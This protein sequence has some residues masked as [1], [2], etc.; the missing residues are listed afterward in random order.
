MVKKTESADTLLLNK[1]IEWMK[2]E[3]EEIKAWQNKIIDT[4][5]EWNDKNDKKYAKK[6]DVDI[7]KRALI[8]IVALIVGWVVT[9]L[10]SKIWL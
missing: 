7:L 5:N 1:E 8:W 2:K 6:E 3:M 9:A 10:L 4:I